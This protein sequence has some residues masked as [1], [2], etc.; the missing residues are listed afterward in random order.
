MSTETV[1][2]LPLLHAAVWTF[3][4]RDLEEA[5]RVLVGWPNEAPISNLDAGQ[6]RDLLAATCR[7]LIQL[8]GDS[9]LPGETFDLILD[10]AG[11][12]RI[13]GG[14][15]AHGARAVLA[16]PKFFDLLQQEPMR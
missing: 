4:R 13:G 16:T 6:R 3:C 2:I 8:D 14:T 11:A 15:Y 5:F 9:I 12:D 7:A 1:N 10:E